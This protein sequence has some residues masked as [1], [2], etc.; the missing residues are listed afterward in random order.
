MRG[1][2]A[3]GDEF[4]EF[5]DDYFRALLRA[6]EF[7]GAYGEWTRRCKRWIGRDEGIG[8]AEVVLAECNEEGADFVEV[9]KVSDEPQ[10]DRCAEIIK[11]RL[12]AFWPRFDEGLPER[13]HWLA[14]YFG[15]M[16]A[17]ANPG[18]VEHASPEAVR[19]CK[20]TIDE[21]LEAHGWAQ[22]TSLADGRKAARLWLDHLS[23]EELVSVLMANDCRQDF[24]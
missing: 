17:L 21:G 19:S 5:Y 12:L 22:D 6:V 11:A 7:M 16:R 15:A 1:R 14:R 23:P 20:Q 3:R 10:V 24:R 13:F 18:F 8:H 4:T 9:L 2:A